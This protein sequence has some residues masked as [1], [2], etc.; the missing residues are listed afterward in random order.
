MRPR[1]TPDPFL[2]LDPFDLHTLDVYLTYRL[3]WISF[4]EKH[5]V[6]PPFRNCPNHPPHL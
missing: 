1:K 4:H 2:I 5:N 3:L 6:Q